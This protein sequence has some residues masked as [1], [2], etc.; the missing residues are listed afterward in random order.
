MSTYDAVPTGEASANPM[1]VKDTTLDADLSPRP[2]PAV[3]T[4]PSAV[5][6]QKF[7]GKV[8]ARDKDGMCYDAVIRRA[9]YGA[10]QAE[11]IQL[12][13]CSH[14][15]AQALLQDRTAEVG[16]DPPCWHYFVHFTKWSAMWD[17]WVAEFDIYEPS[18]AIQTYAQS[19]L[20][21]QKKVGPRL[22][23]PLPKSLIVPRPHLL[24]P[25]LL[26][27]VVATGN[28]S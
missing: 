14:A 6:P 25:N 12:G 2:R 21:E 8:V 23:S 27:Y 16:E 20:N 26:L 5:P 28:D 19:I 11:P 18:D 9:I 4:P 24:C 10:G 1:A 3:K 22:P 7:K 13:L 15:E 17:R